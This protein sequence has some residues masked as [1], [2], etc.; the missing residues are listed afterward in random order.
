MI[1]KRMSCWRKYKSR[2][3]RSVH[4]VRSAPN[5]GNQFRRAIR[6]AGVGGGVR[7]GFECKSVTRVLRARGIF[8]LHPGNV[9]GN[10]KNIKK[11][12]TLI[13]SWTSEMDPHRSV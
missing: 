5:T 9:Y 3:E 8:S 1:I 2:V 6:S 4:C 13:S 12:I 11:I 7:G 10:D